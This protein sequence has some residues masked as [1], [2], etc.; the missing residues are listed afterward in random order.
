[1]LAQRRGLAE[2]DRTFPVIKAEH[3]PRATA[4]P[5][6]AKNGASLLAG[7][8]LA[9]GPI[10]K[11]EMSQPH[12]RIHEPA[13]ASSPGTGAGLRIRCG[14][15]FGIL[16]RIRSASGAVQLAVTVMI[17]AAALA[18]S[19]AMDGWHWSLLLPT[20]VVAGMSWLSWNHRRRHPRSKR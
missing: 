9:A 19:I 7:S 14:S 15:N 13:A 20:G 5:V 4:H 6:L 8:L 16:P 12:F 10:E 11:S 2:F 3:A 1:M 17:I 18:L